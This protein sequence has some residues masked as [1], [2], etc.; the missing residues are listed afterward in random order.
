MNKKS[1]MPKDVCRQDKASASATW[2]GQRPTRGI[3]RVTGRDR[4][5]EKEHK[6]L[7]WQSGDTGSSRVSWC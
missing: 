7:D 1:N 3:Y 5:L 2:A 6:T 4:A